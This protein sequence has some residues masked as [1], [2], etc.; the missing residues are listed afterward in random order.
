MEASSAR[1]FSSSRRRKALSQS[2]MP[3]QQV[4]GLLDL[5][6]GALNLGTH[7]NL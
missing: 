2:K 1:A 3:P 6:G 5:V 4:D 7:G